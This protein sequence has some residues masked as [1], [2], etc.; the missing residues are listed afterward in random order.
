MEELLAL[1]FL[2]VPMMEA[3]RPNYL[4]GA[5]NARAIH[6]SGGISLLAVHSFNKQW[7][8][9]IRRVGPSRLSRPGQLA[10]VDLGVGAPP[11]LPI[12]V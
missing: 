9:G 11:G 5:I 2:Y 10:D 1:R 4:F 12:P 3:L 8:I 7:T 6:S